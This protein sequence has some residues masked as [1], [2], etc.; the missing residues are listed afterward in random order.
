MT[1]GNTAGSLLGGPP[2]V[3]NVGL[4]KPPGIVCP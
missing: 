2:G 4:S 1:E 3:V